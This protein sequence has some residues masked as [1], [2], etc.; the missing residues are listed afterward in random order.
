MLESVYETGND[1]YNFLCCIWTN[2]KCLAMNYQIVSVLSCLSS[3]LSYVTSGFLLLF[4]YE[5]DKK[6]LM[7]NKTLKKQQCIVVY[8]SITFICS[9]VVTT[10]QPTATKYCNIPYFISFKACINYEALRLP[11]WCS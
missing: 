10:H 5:C 2:T 3:P 11:S 8:S 7:G 1:A 9:T 4:C 6:I